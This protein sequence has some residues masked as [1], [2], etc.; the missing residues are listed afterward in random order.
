MGFFDKLFGGSD[1]TETNK[2]TAAIW[3][4]KFLTISIA[5][6]VNEAPGKDVVKEI[7]DDLYT[8]LTEN[9]V[10]TITESVSQIMEQI[11][12]SEV[13]WD[14]V[15]DNFCA[16]LQ[17]YKNSESFDIVKRLGNTAC[18]LKMQEN[19]QEIAENYVYR[20]G[21]HFER[22]T[23]ISKSDFMIIMEEEKENTGYNDFLKDR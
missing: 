11:K 12:C 4:A 6:T 10:L 3:P 19:M 8:D 13:D 9:D 14:T 16:Q 20:M 2:D 17:D 23:T 1:N 15:W 22:Y 7:I 5:E 21:S 18:L